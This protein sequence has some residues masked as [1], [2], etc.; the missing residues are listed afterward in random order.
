MKIAALATVAGLTLS[1]FG[2]GACTNT[3]GTGALVGA[4]AGTAIGAVTTGTLGG[5]AVG[6]ILGAGIGA[7][8][9]STVQAPVPPGCWRY[10]MYGRPYRVC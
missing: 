9:G 8:V 1:G 3:V 10:D 2:L 6:G 7:A 4:G 5:A